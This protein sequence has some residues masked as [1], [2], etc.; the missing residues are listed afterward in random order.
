MLATLISP[1]DCPCGSRL[2]TEPEITRGRCN[3]CGITAQLDVALIGKPYEITNAQPR[4]FSMVT[5][6]GHLLLEVDD[7]GIRAAEGFE[8]AEPTIAA[9]SRWLRRYDTHITYCRLCEEPAHASETTDDDV[10]V[11]C[12]AAMGQEPI[13]DQIEPSAARAG[14][15]RW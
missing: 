6:A 10:C 11:T 8:A 2:A 14:G 1:L 13:E 15:G 5:P 3:A 7:A 12:L 9:F 4:C